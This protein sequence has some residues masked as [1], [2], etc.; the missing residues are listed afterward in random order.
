MDAE[1][2]GGRA[3]GNRWVVLVA[4]AVLMTCAG[5]MYAFSVYRD[6]LVE[7]RGIPLEGVMLAYSIN[8]GLSPVPMMLGG[9]FVDRRHARAV[10]VAGGVLLGAGWILSGQATSALQLQVAYGLVAGLGQGMCYSV[11][12]S[13]TLKLFPD[14]RGLVAGILTGVNGGATIVLAPVASSMAAAD[15]G[16]MMVTLGG[17]FLVLTL[18]ASMFIRSA[19]AAGRPPPGQAS[20]VVLHS[21]PPGRMVR[22]P[23][24][25]AVF[26]CF[27]CGAFSG[28]MIA[29]NAA[30]I[31][32]GMYGLAPAAAALF[33]S[34]YAAANMSGRFLFGFISD[35]AGQIL[36]LAV[37]FALV[38]VS[39][40]VL[41]LGRGSVPALGVGL[42]GLGLCYGGIM[43]VM[44]ALVLT[45]FGP[46][47]QGI[48]Y[49]LAFSAYSVS[50]MIAPP[51]AASIGAE[52][53]GDFT[54]AFLIAIAASGVGLLT[55][56]V[57][58][59]VRG[60]RVRL[61]GR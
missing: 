46:A 2:S 18:L 5:A 39:L 22:T 44:P 10:A 47:H 58:H 25:W 60:P 31:A 54:L 12:L 37:V 48:N 40:V 29:G 34:V 41:V 53:G 7:Q 19:P 6:A 11:G 56:I 50:A 59:R 28:V 43:G 36:T 30:P 52:R 9:Y 26:A 42:V 21:T 61:A 14:R 35:R 1:A 20:A 24:F 51:M 4:A 17:V 23:A 15:V 32:V 3:A 33:V 55:V 38:A 16:R 45:L 49:G 57:L 13:N 27:V 8:M